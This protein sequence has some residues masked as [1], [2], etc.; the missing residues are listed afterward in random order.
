LAQKA[1]TAKF[2]ASIL[3]ILKFRIFRRGSGSLYRKIISPKFFDR[4]TIWPNTVWPNAIWPKVHSTESPFNWTLFDRKFI[5]PKGHMTH[6]FQ[7]MVIWPNLLSTKNVIWPVK[8]A[9]K[10]VWSKV[11]WP[12]AF[13]FDRKVI[14]PK[15]HLTE[16]FFEKLSFDRKNAF[17]KTLRS[18]E[19]SVICHFGHLTCFSS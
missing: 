12:R 7:K 11:L 9:L 18:Y 2:L 19:L 14:W 15:V 8:I 6:F 5:L 17:G 1:L 13:S 3:K 4:N 10:V 16:S